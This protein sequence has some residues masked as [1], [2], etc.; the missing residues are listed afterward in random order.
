[1]KKITR[2]LAIT[3]MLALLMI[4]S[5]C[6]PQADQLQPP[7]EERVP[8]AEQQ[9]P[10]EPQEPEVVKQLTMVTNADFPPYEFREGSEIVGIDPEIAA[11]IAEKLGMELVIEDIDFDS[12]IISVET[13]MFD[14]AMAGLTVTEERMEQVSFSIS[15][16]NGVQAIIVPEGSSI[17]SVDDLFEEG[18]S[19][20]I[21]VQ[22]S[23]TG[24]LYSTWDLEDEGLA[25]IERFARGSDA[26]M[27][28]TSGRI[29]AVIIDNEPARAFVAVNPGLK[30]LDTEFANED[31]AIAL[32]K[33][34]TELLAQVNQALGELIADGT[35]QAI[36][37]KYIN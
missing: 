6:G 12:V 15:Y 25:T 2:I 22:L 19:H 9:E 27:A 35:V 11:A 17:T 32:N 33:G 30:I 36:L 23:T 16:A 4:A 26:V 24:D 14:M 18:A 21:G 3:L 37:D 10:Q 7:E 29:D 5:A 28:L 31:Y 1:M 13:G 34:N 20:S 8:Q